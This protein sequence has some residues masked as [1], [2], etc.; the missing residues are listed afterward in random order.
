MLRISICFSC[1]LFFAVV[2]NFSGCLAVED[3]SLQLNVDITAQRTIKLA[4]FE[5]S[6]LDRDIYFRSYHMPGI[7]S[8][9]IDDDLKKIGAIPGR[10]TGPYY[11]FDGWHSFSRTDDIKTPTDKEFEEWVKKQNEKYSRMYTVAGE[12]YPDVE[13]ALAAAGRYPESMRLDDEGRILKRDYYQDFADLIVGFYDKLKE[14]DCSYPIWFTTENEPTWQ[15]G[16]KEFTDYS[17]IMAKTMNEAHPD[18]KIAGPCT[19]WPYPQTD[20]RRWNGWERPF[21][22]IAGGYM[23]VYD[24]HM[25]SKGYWAFTDER[26]MDDPLYMKQDNPSL[27]SVQRTGIGTVWDY[28]RMDAYLDLFIAYHMGYFNEDPKAM[29]IS[30]FGRQGIEPQL[31]P[32]ENEFKPW[33][34]MTT[35]TRFWMSFMDRPEI[36]L[37][38]PFILGESCIVY[39]ASRGQAIYNR[40]NAPEDTTSKVTRFRDFYKF[41]KDL[42]G[43]RLRSNIEGSELTDARDIVTRAFIDG[44][45]VYILIHNGLGFPDGKQKITINPDI[46]K[47]SSGRQVRVKSSEI[48]RMRWD[49]PV[50]EDH[51]ASELEGSLR[52]ETEYKPLFSLRAIHL[53]GEETAIIRLTLSDIPSK[54]SVTEYLDY[55]TDSLLIP[56]EQGKCRFVLDLPQRSGELT[57]AQLHIALARDQGF[58]K[59]PT[60]TLNSKEL[61]GFDVTHSHGIKNFH[62]SVEIPVDTK[63]LKDQNEII[64]VFEKDQYDEGYTKA[65]TAKMITSRIDAK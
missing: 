6:A 9:E 40:P 55:S 41:F 35:V 26:L 12:R 34:Y 27:H 57:C 23:N 5:K 43:L 44:D 8:E 48:K 38:V 54:K 58:T 62:R 3:D 21:I 60:I 63:L 20:W 53:Q 15:W 17:V 47:N 32:W 56:D 37:A 10:G 51:T 61:D 52:I 45:K 18:I 65:V 36:E 22:E 19:A 50:P 39:G 46:A 4:S 29:I 11:S 59:N 33:L 42:N 14:D 16:S 30:E 1:I 7:F 13:H 28:G 24:L 49:G 31:G 2:L 25:Y 64:V